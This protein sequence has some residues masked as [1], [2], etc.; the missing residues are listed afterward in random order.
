MKRILLINTLVNEHLHQ[1]DI[2][3]SGL[4]V[5]MSLGLHRCGTPRRPSSP[6]PK[7]QYDFSLSP[8]AGER[9]WQK[10]EYVILILKKGIII[11]PCLVKVLLL[12]ILDIT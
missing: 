3:N 6:K 9:G 10:G 8:D 2:S 11:N 1:M 4:E 7:M 12:K 5:L